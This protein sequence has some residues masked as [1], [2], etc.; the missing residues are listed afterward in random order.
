MQF[1]ISIQWRIILFL[2]G[3]ACQCLA[4]RLRAI[5]RSMPIQDSGLHFQYHIRLTL[6]I[7]SPHNWFVYRPRHHQLHHPNDTE[8]AQGIKDLH[9]SQ[10]LVQYKYA[11]VRVTPQP[12]CHLTTA[13]GVVVRL[14]QASHRMSVVR[15]D[16]ALSAGKSMRLTHDA[17]IVSEH[18]GV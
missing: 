7:Y 6:C 9:S 17:S 10:K 14:K 8:N 13:L 16:N 18:P 15:H 11:V 4:N 1:R 12:C 2:C 5:K 3:P